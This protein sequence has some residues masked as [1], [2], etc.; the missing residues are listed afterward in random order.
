MKIFDEIELE[1]D[2]KRVLHLLGYKDRMPDE[3]ILQDV[4]E[5]IIN[6]KEYLKPVVYYK[7]FNISNFEN[8]AVLLEN[9]VSFEGKFIKEKLKNC[10]KIIVTV[11]TLGEEVSEVINKAFSNGDYLKAMIV[12]NISTEA[13]GYTS[14]LFWNKIVENLKNT[15]MGITQTLSPGDTEWDLKE[16]AKIF[17]CMGDD[18][19]EV[20]LNDSF[21][22]IP[23]KTTAA[24]YG[25]GENI[26]VAK[27]EHIC[28][29]CSMKHCAYRS[30][31]KIP[32]TI[33]LNGVKEIIDV[34]KGE[35]LL[36]VLQKNKIYINSPCSGNGTCGKCKVKV[37]KG[38]SKET[39]LDFKHISKEELKMGYRL[40]C[41]IN[42][43]EK[44]EIIINSTE[45]NMEVMTEGNLEEIEI[46]PFVSKIYCQ[47]K[48][49]DLSDQRD[50]LTR[51]ADSCN[52]KNLKIKLSELKNLSN[53]LR[54]WKFDCTAV[55]YNENFLSIEKND[56]TQEFY[57]IAVDI[58]TTTI[59]A[60]LINLN[61]GKTM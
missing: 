40:S 28:T 25:F 29:E 15:N 36:N 49:P 55:I 46:N 19:K 23:S 38:I 47:M 10:N 18:F 51:L 43:T 39:S 59:A 9:N 48:K 4:K 50:D 53:K 1:I 2:E 12:D 3:E 41:A 34:N 22:M 52:I 44:V 54:E 42:I 14:K 33:E 30:D 56:T 7:Y 26:G 60:Y 24:V 61:D 20:K 16:Q 27:K 8:D 37:K 31:G 6:C 35:N 45:N 21:L 11:A 5:E 13:I 58:G 57:G 17:K 32:I